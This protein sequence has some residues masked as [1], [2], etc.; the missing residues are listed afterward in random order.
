VRTWTERVIEEAY[1]FNPAFGATLI[2]ETVNDFRDKG[3]RPFPFAVAFLVLPIVLHE[4]TRKAL[5]K[6]TLT[7]LLPWTQDHRE[8]LVGFAERVRQLQEITRESILFGLQ[9]EILAVEDDGSLAVGSKRK[10]VTLKRTPLFTDEVNECVE[11]CR[12]LGR[13]FAASGPAANIFSSWGIAP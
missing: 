9:T 1:L 11:R 13:W 5:P 4:S 3:K 12:F 10:G 2:A 6:S 7:A 8:S